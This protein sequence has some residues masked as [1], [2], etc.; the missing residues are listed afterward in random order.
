[1]DSENQTEDSYPVGFYTYKCVN[2]YTCGMTTVAGAPVW[3]CPRCG[4]QMT[5]MGG[6]PAFA[7]E[8]IDRH[9]D[10][11]MLGFNRLLKRNGLR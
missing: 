11:I 6:P 8:E 10:E 1:M 5:L 7:D 4:S 2:E 3:E 9:M